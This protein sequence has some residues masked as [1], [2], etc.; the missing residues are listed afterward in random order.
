[1][2]IKR[3]PN[4]K[5]IYVSDTGEV[6]SDKYST[7]P[8]A[9]ALYTD[10]SG[11]KVISFYSGSKRV[12]WL[13]HRLVA[14]VFIP[15]PDNL[16]EVHHI[17]GDRENNNVSNLMWISKAEHS[18][19]EEWLKHVREHNKRREISIRLVD[20]ESQG[21]LYFPSIKSAHA[22]GFKHIESMLSNSG[23]W[24]STKGFVPYRT[25]TLFLSDNTFKDI[26]MHK[27]WDKKALQYTNYNFGNNGTFY[28]R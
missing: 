21:E 7:I 5:H 26:S 16:P 19:D 18:K 8:K 2:N 4:T 11:Y 20:K 1:M 15:N 9:R 10:K 3:V 27:G 23:P 14:T 6:L 25:N 12:T 13:V 28:L 22:V 17:D 24:K